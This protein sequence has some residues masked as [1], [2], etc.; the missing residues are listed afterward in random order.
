MTNETLRWVGS[1][2]MQCVIVGS[3]WTQASFEVA[4]IAA[5]LLVLGGQAV[6]LDQTDGGG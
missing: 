1:W 5:L 4:A 3:L 2:V 6:I